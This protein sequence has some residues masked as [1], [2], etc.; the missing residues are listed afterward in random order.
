MENQ[1]RRKGLFRVVEKDRRLTTAVIPYVKWA[2]F[3][4]AGVWVTRELDS[5]RD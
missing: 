3:Q 1:H 2:V 5:I 4:R